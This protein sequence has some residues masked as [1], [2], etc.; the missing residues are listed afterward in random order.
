MP[1]RLK[2]RHLAVFE[3][4][5][6]TGS[7]TAAAYQLSISQPALS[8]AIRQFEAELGTALF[9]RDTR[10]V[11]LTTDGKLLLPHVKVALI[12]YERLAA[13]IQ[14]LVAGRR[15]RVEL[16]AVS[17]VSSCLLPA[18]LAKYPAPGAVIIRD[19]ENE[20]VK[21]LVSQGR[22]DIGIGLGPFDASLFEECHLF[23][24][25]LHLVVARSHELAM[26]SAVDWAEVAVLN[27]VCYRE[28]SHVYQTIEHTLGGL[29]ILFA[30]A[31]T[32]NFRQSIFGALLTGRFVAILPGMSLNQTLPP[33]LTRVPL[34]S[35]VV[36]RHVSLITSRDRELTADV[37]TIADYLIEALREGASADHVAV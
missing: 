26:R 3:A 35:P 31:A 23:S 1:S 34:V 9:R 36:D 33:G 12:N 5:A 4:V 19:V 20:T 2:L 25:A 8:M 22:A 13:D 6:E 7:F 16:A 14:D 18:A 17:S 30:P 24:D 11:S 28:S 29:R 27:I 10:N 15:A 21:A 32:Y 37:V